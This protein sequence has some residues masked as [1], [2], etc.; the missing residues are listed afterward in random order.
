MG[1]NATQTKETSRCVDWMPNV[2]IRARRHK[3]AGRGF[4][5]GMEASTTKRPARPDHQ[6]YRDHLESNCYRLKRKK[7][8]DRVQTNQ[9]G[10]HDQDPKDGYY[11]QQPAALPLDS[12]CL[13][14]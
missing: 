4:C 10:D 2:P 14:D 13:R 5:R 12:V 3:Y 11:F 6:G 7:A 8:A 1:N 9:S